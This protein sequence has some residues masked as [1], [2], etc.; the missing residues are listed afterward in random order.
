MGDK[1]KILTLSAIGIDSPGLISKITTEIFRLKGNI[2]DVEENCRRGLFSIFLMIDFS[3]SDR[4]PDEIAGS[5][6]AIESNTGLKII[7]KEPARDGATDAP[8]GENYVVIILGM[9][10]P[11]IM[12][13]VS[14]FFHKYNI[15]I[16]N[17]K[18]VARGRIFS[19]EMVIDTAGMT[20]D[21]S[22]PREETIEKMKAELRDLCIELNQSVVVQNEKTYKRLKKVIVF[23][24]ESSLIQDASAMK[25]L[26]GLTEKLKSRERKIPFKKDWEDQMQ[27]LIENAE[28]LQGIPMEELRD[29]GRSLKLHRGTLDLIRILK[30]MGFKIALLSSG[31]DLFIKRLFEKAEVDYAFSNSMK[32]DKD[33]NLTGELEEPVLTSATKNEILEFIM[34]MENITRDQVIAVGDGSTQYPF[35]KNVGLS[36]AYQ[37]EDTDIK[38]DGIFRSDHIINI[39]Y[40]LGI[41]ESELDRYFE[42]TP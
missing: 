17:C 34:N 35:M 39:L 30:S 14:T 38:T 29:L 3:A 42:K 33:G 24:V 26:E 37:P 41:P 13:E 10:Q 11:G 18:M 16:E 6:K 21:P 31:F 27:L 19:M 7:V 22:M 23:D 28:S 5:L 20:I 8:V 9:D 12:A 32:V 36:I 2:I 1:T 15:N 4:T 25:F 40:C